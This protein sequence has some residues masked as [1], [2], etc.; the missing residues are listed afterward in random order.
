MEKSARKKL[1]VRTTDGIKTITTLEAIVEQ[2]AQLA[3]KGDAR[4]R[5]AYFNLLKDA[6]LSDELADG[7]EARMRKLSEED[8]LIFQ[9]Y[10]LKDPV[11]Q[12]P[13]EDQDD[14]S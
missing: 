11:V 6:G 10:L 9:Q 12:N 1:R 14:N 2:T 4:A 5:L 3:L 7:V 8:K 13:T